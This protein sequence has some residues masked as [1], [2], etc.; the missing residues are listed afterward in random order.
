MLQRRTLNT[1]ITQTIPG[2]CRERKGIAYR[3]DMA[4]CPQTDWPRLSFAL[5]KEPLASQTQGL[6]SEGS[7]SITHS[8][9][10]T[11]AGWIQPTSCCGDVCVGPCKVGGTDVCVCVMGDGARCCWEPLL[12]V[13]SQLA[14]Q[15][16]NLPLLCSGKYRGLTAFWSVGIFTWTLWGAPNNT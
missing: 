2:L 7:S 1:F 14:Y 15:R 12:T 3:W 4:S 5:C 13:C 9:C 8:V 10:S 11:L 6:F 16:K